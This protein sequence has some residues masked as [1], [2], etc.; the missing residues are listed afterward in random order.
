MDANLG[1]PFRMLDWQNKHPKASDRHFV[2]I[3][4]S[5]FSRAKRTIG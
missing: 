2:W 4:S 3:L 5:G 1:V